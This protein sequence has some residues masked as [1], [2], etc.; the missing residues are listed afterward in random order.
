VADTDDFLTVVTEGPGFIRITL[1]G[2]STPA[3]L[4]RGLERVVA[5]GASRGIA[6]VLVDAREVPAPIPTIDK[7][8]I[9]IATAHA[10]SSRIKL[11][12]V[13]SRDNVD[14]LFATVARGRGAMVL[15]FTDETEALNW[16]MGAD[17]AT[18]GNPDSTS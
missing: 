11:A 14:H 9:G 17:Q 3:R 10:L 8:D 4:R 15:E 1:S 2:P 18:S 6:R 16:L 13:A 5:E 12:V 7:Y